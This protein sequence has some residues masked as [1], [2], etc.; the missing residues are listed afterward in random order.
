VRCP[1]CDQVMFQYRFEDDDL[2][3]K[4]FFELMNTRG[5]EAGKAAILWMPHRNRIAQHLAAGQFIMFIWPH[6]AQT[7]VK[8]EIE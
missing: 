5:I 4:T 1:E 3:P 8:E 2:T 6:L 7:F